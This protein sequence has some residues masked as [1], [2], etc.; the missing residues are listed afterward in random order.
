MLN[1]HE[2]SVKDATTEPAVCD[3]MDV[4]AE[5]DSSS[6]SSSSDS[7][8]GG[9]MDI[10]WFYDEDVEMEDLTG[11]KPPDTSSYWYQ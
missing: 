5:W 1:T 9:D 11:E 6:C 10:D 3:A 4:D 2:K 7:D 8:D